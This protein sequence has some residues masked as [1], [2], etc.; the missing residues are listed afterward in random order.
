MNVLV[1]AERPVGVIVIVPVYR[2]LGVMV[3]LVEAVFTL[4]DTGPERV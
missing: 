4:P 2:L 3:K 1:I